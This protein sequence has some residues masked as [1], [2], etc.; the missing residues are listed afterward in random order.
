MQKPPS[1]SS[2]EFLNSCATNSK[3]TLMTPMVKPLPV[4]NCDH[5]QVLLGCGFLLQASQLRLC[6]LTPQL[7][8]LTV[9]LQIFKKASMAKLGHS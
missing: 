6:R 9:L 1:S 3:Q 2:P 5:L 8:L 7:T 4:I